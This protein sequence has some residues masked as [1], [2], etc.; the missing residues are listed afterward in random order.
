MVGYWPSSF[1]FRVHGP[2]QSQGPLTRKERTRPIFSHLDQ[3]SLVN[4]GFIIMAFEE[5]F[6]VGLGE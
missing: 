6:P 5:I 2:R 3:T 1:F 4:K